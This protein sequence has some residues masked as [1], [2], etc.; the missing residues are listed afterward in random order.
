MGLAAL[1]AA[2]LP[3]ATALAKEPAPPLQMRLNYTVYFGGAHIAGLAVDLGLGSGAYDMK[4]HVRTEG[5][6]GRIFP[7][8]MKSYSRGLLKSRDVHPIAAGQRNEWRGKQRWIDLEYRRGRAI[9]ASAEPEPDKEGRLAVPEAMRRDAI[10]LGAA[11]LRV[12]L[13]ME[14]GARCTRRVPVFDGR[15]RYDLVLRHRVTDEIVRSRYSA[16][17]GRAASCQVKMDRIG[18]FKRRDNSR[19]RVDEEAQYDEYAHRRSSGRKWADRDRSLSVWIGKVF[20][21]APPMPVRLS[22]DTPYGTLK[23]H[24]ARAEIDSNGVKRKLRRGR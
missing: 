4:T 14:N 1:L 10:D 2:A 11:V 22:V 9:V 16:F 8:W 21:D 19:H 3:F 15:R 24:L 7:W 5:L 12:V 13:A 20:D 23:A 17:K 18:G 6:I